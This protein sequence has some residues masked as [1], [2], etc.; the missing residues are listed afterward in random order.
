MPRPGR[1]RRGQAVLSQPPR[2]IDAFTRISKSQHAAAAA[3]SSRDKLTAGTTGGGAPAS[4]K[5]KAT[6]V[7]DGGRAGAVREGCSS[8]DEEEA[9]RL[10]P[11][12]RPCRRDGG[13]GDGEDKL[14]AG[15]GK[16]KRV[17]KES[18]SAQEPKRPRIIA[19]PRSKCHHTPQL[20]AEAESTGKKTIDRSLPSEFA[21]LV[22]LNRALLRTVVLHMAHHGLNTPV[23]VRSVMPHVSRTWGKREVTVADIRR[24]MAVQSHAGEPSPLT[25]CDYGRGRI[26]IELVSGIDGGGGGGGGVMDEERLGKQFRENLEALCA[27][28]RRAGD[29][30]DASVGDGNGKDDVGLVDA[31]EA[32]GGLGVDV[33]LRRLSMKDL[34]QVAVTDVTASVKTHNAMLLAKGQRALSELKSGA[35][36]QQ[37]AN[38]A[39]GEASSSSSS[40]NNN[41]NN[42]NDISS[43]MSLLDRLRAKKLA[44]AS[45]PPP[46]TAEAMRRRAALNRVGSAAATISMLALSSS[47]SSST[48]RQAF[49]MKALSQKVRDSQRMA[50]SEEEAEACVRVMATEVAP[51]WLRLVT[52]AG[53]ENVVVQ[54]AGQPGDGEVE[55]RVRRLLAT[56]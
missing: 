42:D 26:C 18:P 15:G 41:N 47:S 8:S 4:R 6:A 24:C 2:S 35:K 1:G 22:D 27:G 19:E 56:A 29:D 39:S 17:S 36:K 37:Q 14:K 25:M 28:R 50:M 51:G 13:G 40:N 32:G 3:A 52:L 38:E 11:L 34:P 23:D 45:E 53:R 9:S 54:R 46:P 55:D 48:G 5:R 30:D 7:R 16:R 44:K 43:K 21:E 49:T 33:L 31:D 12:K 20:D 10:V